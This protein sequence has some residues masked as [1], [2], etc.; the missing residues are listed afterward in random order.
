[1]DD[2]DYLKIDGPSL[3]AEAPIRRLTV[4]GRVER[5]ESTPDAGVEEKPR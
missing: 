3:W 1:M 4:Q 5:L 2:G